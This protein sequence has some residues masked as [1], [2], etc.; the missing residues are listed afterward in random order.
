MSPSQLT[1]TMIKATAVCEQKDSTK[2]E[3]EVKRLSKLGTC[4]E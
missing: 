1:L 4:L 3:T 2:K